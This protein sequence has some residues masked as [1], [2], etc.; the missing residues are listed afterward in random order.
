MSECSWVDGSGKEEWTW[1]LPSPCCPVNSQCPRKKTLVEKKKHPFQIDLL[2]NAGCKKVSLN[3]K[4]KYH[5]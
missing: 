2:D 3:L 5:D 1:S 4:P